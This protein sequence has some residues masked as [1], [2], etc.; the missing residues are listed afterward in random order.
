LR[1]ILTAAAILV[2]LA[3]T[4]ALIGPHVIDWDS[5]RAE[6]NRH[7]SAALG[8]DVEVDGPIA[9]SLLPTPRLKL[10]HV[11][12]GGDGAVTGG[13][14]RIRAEAA[15]PPLLRGQLKV[16]SAILQGARITI[17]PTRPNPLAAGPAGF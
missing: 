10:S 1:D 8:Q 6:I 4:A 7:L 12:L 9:V 2:L 15:I 17:D 16:T 3:L 14:A 13:I 11:R 5:R